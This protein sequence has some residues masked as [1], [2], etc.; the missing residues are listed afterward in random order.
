MGIGTEITRLKGAKADLKSSIN[1]KGGALTTELIDEYAAAV[2][3]INIGTDTSDATA[4]ES[5]ILLGETA[6]I[7]DGSKATGTYTPLDTSSGDAVES[8]IV[9]GKKAW[10]DGVEVV[11]TLLYLDHAWF[12]RVTDAFRTTTSMSG[13]FTFNFVNV[14]SA[15]GAFYGCT[16]ITSINV[17]YSNALSTLMQNAYGCT[18][19]VSYT[20][21]SAL[22]SVSNYSQTFTNCSN[23]ETIAGT[24]I[25]FESCTSAANIAA[26]SGCV[27][28]TNIEFALNT[29]KFDFGPDYSPLLSIASLL[30]IANG[31]DGTAVGKTLKMH[32]TSKTNMDAIMVDNN[33]G[34]AELGSAMTLTEFITTIK[35][36]TIA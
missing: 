35:G 36:W 2:D 19:L 7:A 25:S 6:Y 16:N 13:A 33:A 22:S 8:D 24:P 28:L 27:K 34:V 30:S 3:G 29:I 20:I 12:T 18:G 17:T 14:I 5:D 26:F 11:G 32:A 21:N 9:T 23:L 10:V 4:T 31:L 15:V 1:A